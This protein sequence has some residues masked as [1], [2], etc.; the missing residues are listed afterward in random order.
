MS[1]SRSGD[2]PN[3]RTVTIDAFPESAFRHLGREAIVCIDVIR[4]TTTLVS[5]VAQGRQTLVAAG[6]DRAYGL[7]EQLD[8]PILAGEV[9]GRRPS[10]FAMGD[11]P[12]LISQH[13]DRARPL[14]LHSDPGTRLISN[15]RGCSAVY[16]ASYRNMAATVQH[17]AA[18]HRNVALIGAGVHGV[19]SCEDQMAA[20]WMAADLVESGFRSED[21]RTTEMIERWNGVDVA[22]TAW[23]NS[24]AALRKGPQA[25]DL[26][27]VISHVND[28]DLVCAY[29]SEAIVPWSESSGGKLLSWPDS[30][31]NLGATI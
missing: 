13:S 3:A 1:F 19:F 31:K 6:L 25:I 24:A 22:L 14:I 11:S 28:L 29:R 15:T 7:A 21:M 10:G 26:D 18:R 5:S 8:A 17:V 27:F 16:I 12:S 4:T 30:P 20:A 2:A 9:A 23:G